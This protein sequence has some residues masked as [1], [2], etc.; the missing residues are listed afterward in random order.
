MNRFMEI[1]IEQARIGME[2]GHG[3]PFGAVVVRKNKIIAAS[4]NQ[5]LLNNDATAHAE[6]VAIRQAGKVLSHYHLSGCALY[7]TCEPCPMCL[8]AMIWARISRFY[9]GCSRFDAAELGFKDEKIYRYLREDHVDNLH[10]EQIERRSCLILFEFW[11]ELE[12]KKLY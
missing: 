4:H 7:T 3:G 1:A 2:Q 10:A 8:A 9:Y 12:Q 11:S 6:I 5:V